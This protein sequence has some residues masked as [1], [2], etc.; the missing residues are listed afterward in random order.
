MRVYIVTNGLFPYG[1]ASNKRRICMA[2]AML[3]AG[4]DCE[5]VVFNWEDNRSDGE[6]NNRKNCI[7]EGIPVR[8]VGVGVKGR[9]KILKRLFDVLSQLQLVS[10]LNKTLNPGDAVYTY[11]ND[12]YVKSYMNKI[13]RVVHKKKA[14]YLR[15][16]CEL[17]FGTGVENSKAISNRMRIL[18]YQFPQ[19]DGVITISQNLTELARKH[20]SPNC[21]VLQLPIL[22][23]YDKYAFEDKS[24][25]VD[26]PFIF[27]SG[28][29]SEQK[30]GIIGMIEAFGKAKRKMHKPIQFVFTG[31]IEN[32]THKNEIIE[33]ISRYDL[34]NCIHFTGFVSE[35]KLKDYLGKAYMV[36]IN[37]YPS[38]QNYYCFSTK[39]GEYMA[40]GKAVIITNVGEAMNWLT[41]RKDALIVEPYETDALADAIV[42][43]FED[44][45]LRTTLGENARNTCKQKFDYNIYSQVFY[46]FYSGL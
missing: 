17:P 40:A 6:K 10:F 24:N 1:M 5:I 38:Q 23:E 19:Y 31:A 30:D 42:E 44:V 7:F 35:D 46:D 39:L 37:K 11:V 27:H 3:K 2:K 28:T 25:T 16:L 34:K 4:I 33:L 15:E 36:I 13:I 12:K 26:I 45:T 14:K 18:K 32:S 20:V 21:K 29:L 43:V 9:N 22:V 8:F 41:N